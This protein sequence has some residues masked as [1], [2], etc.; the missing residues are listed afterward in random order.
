MKRAKKLVTLATVASLTLGCATNA[1][2]IISPESSTIGSPVGVAA[3]AAEAEKPAEATDTAEAA[4]P[5][6]EVTEKHYISERASDLGVYP[7]IAGMDELNA[8]IANLVWSNYSNF[9]QDEAFSA[10]VNAFKVSYE[11]ANEGKY[12]K[13]TLTLNYTK[14]SSVAGGQATDSYVYYIDKE[15][16]AEMTEDAYKAAVEA[17]PAEE[18]AAPAE[19]AAAPAEEAAAEI[20]MMPLRA[21]TDILGGY[22]LAWNGEEKSVAV[23]K[24][25][26]VIVTLYVDANKYVVGDKEVELDAAPVNQDGS[27][28]VPASF[29]TDILGVKVTA[30]AEGKPIVSP[31]R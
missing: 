31:T 23:S 22:A 4:Y 20:V 9:S 17:K 25:D 6:L 8:K 10:D 15:A 13:V 11:V 19:E 21:N 7:V 30:D 16:A 27:V 28:Y 26:K 29:F 2:A 3:P 14:N 5:D 12:A 1:F 24:D 18:A